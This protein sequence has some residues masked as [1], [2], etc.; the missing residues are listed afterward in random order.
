MVLCPS[1][2]RKVASVEPRMS[3]PS[4]SLVIPGKN[5]A[6]T[7]DA[8]LEAVVPLLSTGE[9]QEIIVVDDGSTDDTA[10]K[11]GR[12]PVRVLKTQGVGP[13]AARN[14]GW[15][16]AAGE[17]VWFLDSDCVA[18]VDAL[19]L[20][21]AHLS[22]PEVAGA[23]G[24][25]TNEVPDSALGWLIH[26]EIVARHASIRGRVTHLGTYNVLYRR[27]VLDGVGGFDEWEFNGP[28]APGAEDADLS[29]RIVDAGHELRLEPESLAGHFH[30]TRLRSYWRAQWLHGY[31]G[32]RLYARHPTKAENSYSGLLDHL[33][34]PWAIGCVLLLPLLFF[35]PGR[36]WV[37]LGIA[38]AWLFLLVLS[39]PFA[40]RLF[41]RTKSFRALGYP[42][43]SAARALPRGFGMLRGFVSLVTGRK[44]PPVGR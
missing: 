22:D 39:I 28:G 9:L 18:R 1:T 32:A 12:F 44:T 17:C 24:S 36:P 38:I 21:L 40:I 33:Q 35:A 19:S 6:R 3:S 23:G 16:N 13:G 41:A 10:E 20:L 43:F 37:V 25:Y 7:I 11:A 34:P 26:E 4:V 31:W 8:C 5:A 2:A 42:L 15:Q 14:V 27:Q 30:P 29:Y